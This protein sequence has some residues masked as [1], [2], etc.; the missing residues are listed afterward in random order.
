MSVCGACRSPHHAECWE[1]NGGCA[2]VACPKGPRAGDQRD[3]GPPGIAATE[4]HVSVSVELASTQGRG[5]GQLF[6]ADA[7]AG[8]LVAGGVFV[9]IN[10][11]QKPSAVRTVTAE[12]SEVVG[13]QPT[14]LPKRPSSKPVNLASEINR[15]QEVLDN[16]SATPSALESAGRL[17]QF[18]YR[19][20]SKH[21][22]LQQPTLQALSPEAEASARAAIRATNAITAIVPSQPTLPNWR[23]IAP[24]PP[25]T[26][27]RYFREAEATY[28][29]PWQY[30]AAIE[31]LETR[32]GRIRG[33]SSAGAQGPM[34]FMPATWSGYG[35][36]NINSQHDSILAAARLLVANGA[37]GDMDSALYH[38]NP[39]GGYVIA[40]KSYANEM[41]ANERSFYGYYYW[42]VFYKHVTGTLILPVGYPSVRPERI[43]G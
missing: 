23:I 32:M 17:E 4:A 34:Q 19:E 5:R 13:T 27:L 8:L 14:D 35:R 21:P 15:A 33:A 9:L 31:L 22:E 16:T 38:Y 36:G 7:V 39:N 6:A 20:L 24:P 28:D 43:A 42:Q 30:L 11:R 2:V 37:P 1:E 25:K 26:L 18:A 29:V 12:N 3:A 10:E 41:L 40:I